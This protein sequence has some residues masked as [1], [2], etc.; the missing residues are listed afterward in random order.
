[1]TINDLNGDGRPEV[2]N[3][4]SF[5]RLVHMMGTTWRYGRTHPLNAL[6]LHSSLSNVSGNSA[7]I[8]LPAE[9]NPGS[10]SD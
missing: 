3:T 10:V 5:N 4:Y 9:Y 7:T 1:M 8:V 6:T 2:I